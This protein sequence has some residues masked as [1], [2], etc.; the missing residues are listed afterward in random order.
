MKIAVGWDV[1]LLSLV[2]IVDDLELYLEDGDNRF[3]R[4]VGNF[5]S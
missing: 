5:L 4:N 2:K 1:L 3:L